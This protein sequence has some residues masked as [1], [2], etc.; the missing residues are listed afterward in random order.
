MKYFIHVHIVLKRDGCG[1]PLKR[2][3]VLMYKL[4]TPDSFP[5]DI[6]GIKNDFTFG[7]IETITAGAERNVVINLEK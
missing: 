6:S 7:R 5:A 3:Y 4:I 1:I 2:K